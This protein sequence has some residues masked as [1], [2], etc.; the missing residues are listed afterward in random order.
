VHPGRKALDRLQRLYISHIRRE[1]IRQ[2]HISRA[3]ATRA[4]FDMALSGVTG[5]STLRRESSI[6]GQLKGQLR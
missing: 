2:Q 4:L 1:L 6:S 3:A 5:R